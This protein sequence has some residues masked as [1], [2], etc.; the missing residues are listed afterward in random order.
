MYGFKITV[1][2]SAGEPASLSSKLD[3]I[4]DQL[5][6]ASHNEDRFKGFM[7]RECD[8][9]EVMFLIT[10]DTDDEA[11]A[12]TLAI[13]WLHSAVHAAGFATPGWL[14]CAEQVFEGAPA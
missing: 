13:S 8:A 11:T 5:A 14:R 1:T 12:L 6:L 9:G 2:I 10:A 4:A 7:I 3:E